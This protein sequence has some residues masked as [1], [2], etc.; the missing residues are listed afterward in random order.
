MRDNF[1]AYEWSIIEKGGE[2]RLGQ[3]ERD[4]GRLE[5]FYTNWTLKVYGFILFS[6]F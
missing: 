1:T 5:L 3:V 6:L 4:E 2:G